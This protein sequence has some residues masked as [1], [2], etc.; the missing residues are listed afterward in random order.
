MNPLVFI[1]V[2]KTAGT[3]FRFGVDQLL[4][5]DRVVRDYGPQSPETS[6]IVRDWVL[7][8]RDLWQFRREFDN[9]GYH[10]ITGHFNAQRYVPAFGVQRCFT[11]LRDPV[12]RVYSEYQ[13]FVRNYE[14]KQDFPT[15]YR[16]APFINRQLRMF[17]NVSWPALGMIGFTEYYR[18]SLEF[19]EAKFGLSVP[20][21]EE[22]RGR[23]NVRE[24]EIPADQL[25]EVKKI[26]QRDIRF[27]DAALEQFQWRCQLKNAGKTFTAGEVREVR[28]GKLYGWAA[29]ETGDAPAKIEILVNGT[30]HAQ[31]FA[32]LDRPGL[33]AQG[34]MRN[35]Q[36]GFVADLPRVETGQEIVCRVADTGQILPNTYQLV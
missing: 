5:A 2:P 32:R 19:V 26:N 31:V 23:D 22:N 17:D 18:E 27:Y 29:P 6:S 15:F 9:G 34:V 8:Q 1:H 16:S 13:H 4:G 28:D 25:E 20:L 35:G 21:L 3:S 36:V 7:N 14:Y 24:Y 10:F 11:F 30:V 33:R 12:Q